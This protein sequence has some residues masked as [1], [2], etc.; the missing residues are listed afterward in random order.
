MAFEKVA[1]DV[2]R[3]GPVLLPLIKYNIKKVIDLKKNAIIT[4]FL[5]K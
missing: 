1:A 5:R 2:N 3:N 4:L